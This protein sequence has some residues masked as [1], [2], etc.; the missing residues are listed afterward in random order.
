M[1]KRLHPH[2][3]ALK[4]YYISVEFRSQYLRNLPEM[5]G[6]GQSV[7]SHPDLQSTRGRKDADQVVILIYILASIDYQNLLFF[8]SM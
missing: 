7:F 3:G 1:N 4:R 8:L 6:Q 5:D 2:R